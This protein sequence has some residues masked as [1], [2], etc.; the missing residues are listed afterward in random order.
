VCVCFTRRKH[1]YFLQPIDHSLVIK[2]TYHKVHYRTVTTLCL[3]CK[4]QLHHNETPVSCSEIRPALCKYSPNE[5]RSL[6]ECSKDPYYSINVTPSA[7]TRTHR[8]LIG[9]RQD[10]LL[11]I[12]N[13][14]TSHDVL[15]YKLSLKTRINTPKSEACT[16][17]SG[18]S[19]SDL[20]W[21]CCGSSLAPNQRRTIF[22]KAT[23][24]AHT[25][26]FTDHQGG[27]FSVTRLVKNCLR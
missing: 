27:R 18:R 23:H 21:G 16:V 17:S 7:T 4:Q 9:F 2:T 24:S 1:K 3:R 25:S 10:T 14:G 6:Y 13:K 8:L 11:R 26:Q 20:H 22:G 19:T 5:P 15:N 12:I